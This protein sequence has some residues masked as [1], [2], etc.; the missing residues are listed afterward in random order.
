M[1]WRISANCFARACNNKKN[2]LHA[3]WNVKNQLRSFYRTFKWPYIWLRSI[4][5]IAISYFTTSLWV[6]QWFHCIMYHIFMIIE[7]SKMHK[8]NN[9]FS[10]I[11]SFVVVC[12][13]VKHSSHTVPLSDQECFINQWMMN[14]MGCYTLLDQITLRNLP[15]SREKN[16]SLLPKERAVQVVALITS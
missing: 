16:L 7:R 8:T 5:N 13:W 9:K 2:K 4:I 1:K 6:G 10:T 3:G 14:S 15:Q 12:C 11:Y